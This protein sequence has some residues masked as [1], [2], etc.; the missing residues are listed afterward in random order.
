MTVNA[1]EREG[2]VTVQATPLRTILV[3][4]PY[5]RA[6]DADGGLLLGLH[7]RRELVVV[8]DGPRPRALV[9]LESRGVQHVGYLRLPVVSLEGRRGLELVAYAARA[10]GGVAAEAGGLQHPAVYPAGSLVGERVAHFG[11]HLGGLLVVDA[12]ACLTAAL[13]NENLLST[14]RGIRHERP[15]TVLGHMKVSAHVLMQRQDF[16]PATCRRTSPSGSGKGF[17]LLSARR[18]IPMII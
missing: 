3:R 4:A 11:T 7:G 14:Y 9:P 18:K 6:L 1:V 13:G 17:P 10:G 2:Q 16:A 12:Q 8:G 15:A 5:H